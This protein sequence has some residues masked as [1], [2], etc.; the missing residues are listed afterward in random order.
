MELL[1]IGCG[2]TPRPGHLAIDRRLGGEAYPLRTS[3]GSPIADNSVDGAVASHVL[4]HFSHTQT[5]S[6]LAEWVRVLKPGGI[7]KVA[8]PDMNKVLSESAKAPG[9]LPVE[10]YLMGGHVDAN[11]HHGALFTEAKLRRLMEEAGLVDIGPWTSE[12]NDCAALPISLNLQG[13]KPAEADIIN[14]GLITPNEV[15]A[16]LSRSEPSP[17]PA[18]ASIKVAAILS[19]PRVG[20]NDF[21]DCATTALQTLHIPLRSFKGVFWGQCMQRAFNECCEQGIDW[22]LTLDYDSLF[23]AEHISRLFEHLGRRPD[24]DAIAALQCRR[25]Q[26]FPL[27][28]VGHNT[29]V[30]LDGQPLLATT[31]HFGL[32]VIRVEALKKCKKP[33]FF[34]QP[35]KDGEWGD[36]RLDDDI[37]FWH[38]WRLAGNTIYVAPDVQIGHMEEM[39][40]AYDPATMEPRHMYVREWR[41]MV[42]METKLKGGK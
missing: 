27:M 16:E 17:A 34:G 13:R 7:L 20:F 11:D 37:W 28:T 40:A 24:I 30:E 26:K 21:W 22:I 10:A 4:E 3:G 32:T 38:Q 41:E 12:I 29:K 35:D 18:T 19:R 36:E 14:G 25:G 39:V 5:A 8:V 42:G 1:D 6:V 15:L 9:T 33:W 31:A 2:T 23:T